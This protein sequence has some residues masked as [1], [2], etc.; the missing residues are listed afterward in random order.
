MKTGGCLMINKLKLETKFKS[1][2]EAI[3][4]IN[5]GSRVLVGGFGLRGYPD[6]LVDALAD[7]GIGDLTIISNDLGSPGI[8]L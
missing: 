4:L 7:S 6:V 2:E 8:G 5:P 3:A 1:I